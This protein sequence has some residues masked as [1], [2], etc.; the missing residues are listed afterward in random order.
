MAYQEVTPHSALRRWVDRFWFDASGPA[1]LPLRILPDG[2]IDVIVDLTAAGRASVVGAMTRALVVDPRAP[3]RSVAVRFRP[4][5]AVP[6]LRVPA[7]EL[8]DC[9][10]DGEALGLR[11]LAPAAFEGVRDLTDAV[12]R[13]ERLLLDRLRRVSEPDGIV[14]HVVAALFAREPPSIAALV[15]ETGWSRQHLARRFRHDVG[16]S[17]KQLARV[18]RLQQAVRHLQGVRAVGLAEAALELG[19]F[20]QA[21]MA[22]DFRDLVGLTPGD[23][24]GARGSI[25]PIT[26][27]LGEPR[28]RGEHAV[29]KSG[30]A[31]SR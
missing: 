4:G 16:V 15:E 12:R 14:A 20:D 26:S 10:V 21:H 9:R 11:W 13:L 1:A 31:S 30:T 7:D 8:T 5:G 23:V 25:H 28:S 2:C 3:V 22:L 18:A 19:Y 29:L 17:P 24:R 27:L 6:F